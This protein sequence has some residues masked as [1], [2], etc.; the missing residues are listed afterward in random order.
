MGVLKQRFDDVRPENGSIR[1]YN[2]NDTEAIVDYLMK[3]GH[4]VSEIQKNRV[5]LEEYYIELMSRKEAR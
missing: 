3:H 4:V 2:V 5:G 1:V